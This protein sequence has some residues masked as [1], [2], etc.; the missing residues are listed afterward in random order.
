MKPIA[1]LTLTSV[2]RLNLL[3]FL[4]DHVHCNEGKITLLAAHGGGIGV[5]TKATCSLCEKTKD[6]TDYG[7]W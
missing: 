4:C 2:E 6:I 1:E 7:A 5:A 3:L